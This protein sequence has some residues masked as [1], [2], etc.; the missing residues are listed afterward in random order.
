MTQDAY[1]LFTFRSTHAAIRA[2]ALLSSVRF[3]VM[4][5]LRQISAS[6]G[7]SLRVAPEQLPAAQA[8]LSTLDTPVSLYYV[9]QSGT[10]VQTEAV[11][12]DSLPCDGS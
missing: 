5:T 6:C 7:I 2:Q 10:Q 11:F 1:Y 12:R 9:T 8:A 4:P 3:I